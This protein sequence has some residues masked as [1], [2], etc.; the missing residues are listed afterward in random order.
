MTEAAEL[1]EHMKKQ[2]RTVNW[3]A[4]LPRTTSGI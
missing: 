2:T 1:V 3:S 4:S